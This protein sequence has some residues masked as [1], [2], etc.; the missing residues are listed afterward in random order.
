MPDGFTERRK[1]AGGG[2]GVAG[3]SSD[4]GAT[5]VNGRSEAPPLSSA[6]AFPGLPAPS[7][8]ALER[9]SR[10]QWLQA[11]ASGMSTANSDTYSETAS[12]SNGNG[13]PAAGGGSKKKSKKKEENDALRSL[14]MSFK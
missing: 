8:Q 9:S 4:G 13:K 6:E 7:A 1:A 12:S 2:W 11:S 14:A 3:S 10:A 5:A